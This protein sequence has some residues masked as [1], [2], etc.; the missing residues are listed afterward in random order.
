MNKELA[1]IYDPSNI[2]DKWYETWLKNDAFKPKGG[3]SSHTIMIPPPNVTGILHLG[4]VL[5]N[6]LQDVFIRRARMQGKNALWLPGTDHA[7]IATEA[8]VTK[9]LSKQNIDKKEIGRDKFLEHCWE[10]TDKYGGIIT[11]QLKRLG[12]SCD[13][14]K[15]EFTMNDSYYDSVIQTFVKLYNEGLIYQGRRMINWD[16]AGL[17]ALSNEEVIYKEDKGF[18][19][20]LK[21]PIKDSSD[22]L[23]VATTRPETMLGDT[24]VAVNPKDS[25]YKQYIGKVILLPITNR[26]IPIFEDEYVDKDFGTGCVK[27]TP[28]HDPNDYQMAMRNDLEVINIMNRDASVNE[29]VTEK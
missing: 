23:T 11:K 4:H 16:P 29:Q 1:K 13:W 24:G 14:S 21:Y 20:H 15:E 6:S 25:R 12:C 19:W 2:E 10:W 8:K 27:V 17:T 18:L 26:E 5:N 9:L 3:S 7:S 28:A 22:Y